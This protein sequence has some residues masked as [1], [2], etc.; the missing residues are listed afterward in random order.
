MIVQ[1]ISTK[2]KWGFCGQHWN[3]TLKKKLAQTARETPIRKNLNGEELNKRIRD[4]PWKKGTSKPF[5]TEAKIE[6]REIFQWA[7]VTTMSM[8]ENFNTHKTFY[9]LGEGGSLW[10]W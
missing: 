10:F 8:N 9:A 3:T 2:S 6:E 4:G 5:D 7:T 1:D